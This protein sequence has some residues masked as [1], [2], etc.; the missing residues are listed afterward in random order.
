[1]LPSGS[2]TCIRSFI[3][4]AEFQF[5][6][7]MNRLYYLCLENNNLVMLIVL[8]FIPD[9]RSSNN[10][11]G[12]RLILYSSRTTCNIYSQGHC[13]RRGKRTRS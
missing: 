3:V 1:M 6:H 13:T 9:R 4:M 11:M 12:D 2:L 5:V 7:H 8:N 10:C